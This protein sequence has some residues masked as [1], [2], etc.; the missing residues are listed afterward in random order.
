MPAKAKK[1]AKTAN[2]PASKQN[3]QA[4]K[5]VPAGRAEPTVPE[6]GSKSYYFHERL[7]IMFRIIGLLFE[8][9]RYEIY[10]ARNKK[11][12]RDIILHFRREKDKRKF[13][14]HRVDFERTAAAAQQKP[15]REVN[16]PW[17]NK[18]ERLK[19]H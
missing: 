18:S 4:Q 8:D 12:D 16:L 11:Y 9:E 1:V 7:G 10:H 17:D 6:K 14:V 19:G 15:P 3:V 5:T 13:N 2:I